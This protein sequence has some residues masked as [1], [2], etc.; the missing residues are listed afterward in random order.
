[1][2]STLKS[3]VEPLGETEFLVLLRERRLIHSPGRGSRRFEALL[4]WETLNHLLDSATLPLNSLRVMRESVPIPTNFYLKHGRVDPTALSKLLD[5]GVSLIFNE[6]DEQVPALGALCKNLERKTSERVSAAAIMTSGRG[7]ALKCHYDSNDLVILQI[8]GTKRWQV[9][10][11]PV[12]NP[13]PGTTKK[14]PP[15]RLRSVFDQV[16]H[17]GDFLFLPAGHW[18]HCEN[19]QHRSLH[20][21]I[22]FEP[23]SGRNLL[24]TLVSKLSLDETFRRPLTRHSSVERLAEHE[25]ALRAR[26]IDAIQALSLER[27]LRERAALRTVEGIRL[28]GAD[29]SGQQRSD[30]R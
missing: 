19:G 12:V 21:C 27:F 22:L 26:I 18:H 17:P 4:N 2:I 13:V 10:D 20:V 15:E 29:Q 9:F 24:Q 7:G 23:P 3:L 30:V 14:A 6:L 8:A 25:N 11:S 16:L 5:Q 28:E 1:M